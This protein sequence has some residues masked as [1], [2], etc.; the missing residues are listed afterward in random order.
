VSADDFDHPADKLMQ[1]L[2]NHQI[3][4]AVAEGCASS[5][6]SRISRIPATG[7]FDGT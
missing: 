1:L 3:N 2:R 7:A 6:R 5:L 4:L